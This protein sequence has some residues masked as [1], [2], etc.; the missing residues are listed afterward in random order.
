MTMKPWHLMFI[1][2]ATLGRAECGWA[3]TVSGPNV[4]TAVKGFKVS[5]TTGEKAGNEVDFVAERKDKPTVYLFVQAETWS[6][7]QGRFM[8]ILDEE[9]AKGIEGAED[10]AV[11]A[12]WLTDD[13]AMSK[14]YLPRVHQSLQF[15]KTTL[16]VFEGRKLGPDD[17][18]INDHAYLT[19]VV[20]RGGSVVASKGYLSV[21]E[22]DVADVVKTLKKP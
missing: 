13:A 20:V 4:G 19:A 22:A 18:S 3:Q 11:V 6:R 12:V 2:A 16:A 21:S 15:Q 10:A 7:P 9:I 1:A 8:R 17:W 14:D 5:A